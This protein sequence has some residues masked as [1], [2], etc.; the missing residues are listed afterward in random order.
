MTTEERD[1]NE[2]NG[3]ARAKMT[4]G[5]RANEMAGFY[6]GKEIED[7]ALFVAWL[8]ELLSMT[9]E[10]IYDCYL[11]DNDTVVVHWKDGYMKMINI[12]ANSRMA[13]IREVVNDE[14]L[15]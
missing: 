12:A 11:A 3:E 8:G 6:S 13:I 9:R 15:R 2:I 7:K 5:K 4:L 10:G 1:W 14:D